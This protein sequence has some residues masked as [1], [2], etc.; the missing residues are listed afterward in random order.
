MKII[1]QNWKELI[2][3][4]RG[5]LSAWGMVKDT[6]AT[7]AKNRVY[8]DFFVAGLQP[9]FSLQKDARVFTVGSCFAR[10][11][12]RRL[13][14]IGLPIAN[15]YSKQARFVKADRKSDA[16]LF[17]RFNVASILYEIKSICDPRWL[18]DSKLMY[19]AAPGQF[20]DGYF[21]PAQGLA[22]HAAKVAARREIFEYQS[23]FTKQAEAVFITLGMSEAVFDNQ[24]QMYLNGAPVLG[25]FNLKNSERFEGHL[26]DATASIAMLEEARALLKKYVGPHVK[27]VVTVS[28]VPLEATF[29]GK[30]IVIANAESKAILRVAAA[31]FARKFD[32]VDYFPSYEM[33]TYS[34]PRL[35]FAEDFRHVS[36]K[37]VE[38]ITG[39]FVDHYFR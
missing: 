24:Y 23:D 18:D 25:K 19:E 28:P 16:A 21:S 35:A 27:M 2:S 31:E 15:K 14:S 36:P 11:I 3:G 12:E 6:Q 4:F 5:E 17:N 34:D 10:E 7:L 38:T 33:V 26:I 29:T 1:A 32:D 13:A 39:H 30:D 9:K 20:Y 37:M 22:D 8:T